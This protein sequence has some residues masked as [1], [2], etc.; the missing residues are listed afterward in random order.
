MRKIL[1]IA[2][3]LCLMCGA[4]FASA[5]N[6]LTL[7]Y[8]I[9]GIEDPLKENAISRLK[10]EQK[11]IGQPL[12]L[13]KIQKL[14]QLGPTDV[15]SAL[16]PYGYF[17]PKITSS[18]K[19]VK[20]NEWLA[21]FDVVKGRPVKITQVNISIK[22]AGAKQ[23]AFIKYKNTF[24]LKPGQ[25]LDTDKYEAQ[26]K[27]L[28]S[29]ATKAGFLDGK[30][31]TSQVLV[32]LKNHSAKIILTYNTGVQYYFGNITFS[33]NPMDDAF[34]RRY[35]HFKP[36]DKYS[37]DEL[38]TLQENLNGTRY[39]SS[40]SVE[41]KTYKTAQQQV[42]IQVDL[43]P[44]K[45]SVY[46]FGLGYGT[47]TGPRATIGYDKNR[48]T[49]T[50]QYFTSYLQ[51]STV[52]S[53]LEAKYNIPGNNPTYQNYFIAASASEQSPNTSQGYTQKISVGKTDQWWGWQ[54][55]ISLSTQWDQYQLR[56]G[57]REHSH[58]LL[59]SLTLSKIKTDDPIFPKKGYSVNF[60]LLGANDSLLSTTSFIQPEISGKMIFSPLK[61]IRI[62]T[63]G[64]L[65]VT[66]TD[67]IE[68]VPLSLQFFAGGADS[69]R[70]YDYQE[71]GPGKYLMVGSLEFQ[72]EVIDKWYAA[73][74]TDFGNAVNSLTS[75]ENSVVGRKQSHI[76]LNQILK[77]SAGVGV[78][79]AS[80]VGPM[81]LTVAKPITDSHKKPR[82]Q[83]TMGANL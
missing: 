41:P 44:G 56:R 30:F 25:V 18:L 54:S 76:D 26:K 64:D 7:N 37:P 12:T 9:H 35:L 2:L 66:A 14:Y 77:Y 40:V 50:G 57:P 27:R 65:G 21:S 67:N 70:G 63:R 58:L 29:I 82:I 51:G 46:N 55:T 75:P 15:K 11:H 6:K 17:E 23:K 73:I 72:Y 80:P 79:W 4:V 39:F 22:G 74:F 42:P 5:Q 48:I 34:L 31:T 47:D 61:R 38:M 19:Q 32:N 8:A 45:S 52:Q 59:P 20:P 36:G 13:Q 3:G 69:I 33:K 62:V 81:E 28:N 43:K 60:N 16:N 10:I 53:T 24:P 1:L 71:L 68:L 83:F 49:P 78:V